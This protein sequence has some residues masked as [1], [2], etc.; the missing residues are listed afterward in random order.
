MERN[1]HKLGWWQPALQKYQQIFITENNLWPHASPT[2]KLINPG[3]LVTWYIGNWELSSKYIG[4]WNIAFYLTCLPF[5]FLWVT[6]VLTGQIACSNLGYM[7]WG[8]G[9]RSYRGLCHSSLSQ[10]QG[11]AWAVLKTMSSWQFGYSCRVEGFFSFFLN[12]PK[13]KTQLE[14]MDTK[15]DE[16]WKGR[17]FHFECV[18]IFFVWQN[19]FWAETTFS[20]LRCQA[21][22]E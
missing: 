13:T 2:K 17:I 15:K 4:N 20:K 5:N 12:N 8:Q 22:H 3:G 21:P 14:G 11:H 18:V 16:V 19:V 1:H 7:W 6:W 9:Q 10:W